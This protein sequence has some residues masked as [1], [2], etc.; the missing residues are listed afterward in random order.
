MHEG[1]PVRRWWSTRPL[2][3]VVVAS[4]P[5]YAP[6]DARAESD[7]DT[8][9]R[10]S[11][12]QTPMQAAQAA[13]DDTEG[14]TSPCEVPTFTTTVVSKR[15]PS[16]GT[17]SRIDAKEISL[18][19][20]RSVPEALVMEPSVE[21]HRSPKAGATLQI[22][23]FDERAALLTIEGIPVR[24]IYDG[25]FDIASLPSFA[26]GTIDMERG[27][28]SLLYG[29]N[30][31]GAILALRAP[32]ACVE[33][34]DLTGFGRP[35]GE[36]RLLYGGKLKA[37]ARLS[38]VTLFASAGYE[39][40]DGY[41]LS[42]GYE[43]T[44]HNA[45]FHERGGVRD[46]SDY[47]RA[48]LAVA[49]K[50]APR[51]NKSVSLFVNGIHSPRS[52][53]P[54][55]GFGYLRLWRFAAYDTLLA[56]LSGTYG[57][58][59]AELPL[60]WG[61]REAKGQ[62]YA[63]VHRD[64]IRDY[65]DLTYERLTTNPLAWFVASAYANETFGAAVQSAWALNSGNRLDLAL[66]Y[67]LD[68]HAQR[69]M[70]VPRNG[71]ST[72]WT[73]WEHYSAH[74]FTIAAE[75]T[76]LLGPLRLHGGLAF[77]GM[78]LLA[79]QIRD[80]NYPVNRRLIPAFE[81]RLML[82]RTIAGG[83]RLMAAAGHKV[84][85]PMLK[86]LFSNS[87]GGNPDLRAERAWMTESGFDT[88]D[89]LTKNFDTSFRLFWNSIHDLIESYRQAYANVGRA[90]TGGLEAEVRYKP[91]EILQ[92]FAGYRYLYARDLTHE[93]PLD[94]RTPH[95]VIAGTRVFTAFGLTA[96]A[97]ATYSSEQEAYYVDSLSGDWV[98]D[99]LAG[100]FVANGHLRYTATL[101]DPVDLYVFVDGFNLFDAN[102]S[103][104]S[105]EPRSGREVIFGIGGRL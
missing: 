91:F 78:S 99:R 47:E 74:S 57:P 83:I 85:F 84:R 80:T 87:I 34:L 58:E 6:L 19:G 16:P 1:A 97:E 89:F 90:M 30:T 15:R 68:R 86:E 93:R 70:P 29:P 13:C 69:E 61:F 24:E 67:N 4:C 17:N 79:E 52:V 64:E 2:A 50:Y 59:P 92:F 72:G 63:H 101:A 55:E 7:T 51:K 73:G 77:S 5:A 42:G 33:T 76:Q 48:S 43:P 8:G 45:Q 32:D 40:S 66:R 37:C 21:V 46:G 88:H 105:F 75:D 65:E 3:L 102:Y 23:G 14:N 94:Y 81:S 60:T 54:F 53:P 38:D 82:E 25:H 39:H 49:A 98:Q 36:D 41:V 9:A 31:A 100:Y 96:A 27:V 22:R 35:S 20:A 26:L 44:K 28:T 104:G 12:A 56:G 95:R 103:A 62:I 11:S 71:A 10:A 18:R